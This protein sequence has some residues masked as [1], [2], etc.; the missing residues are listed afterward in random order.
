MKVI[1]IGRSHDN[2]V[3]IDDPYVGRHHCQIVQHDNGMFTIVDMNSTNGTYINGRRVFGEAQLQPYDSVTI[4]HTILPWRSYFSPKTESYALPIVLGSVGGVLLTIVLALLIFRHGSEK[5]FAFKGDYPDAVVVNMV[6]EDGT[7]Y[8]IEAIE[9]QVCVWFEEGTP[10][11]TAQK[12]I[13]ASGGRIVAQIPENG[14]YLVK[15]P[16]DKVNIFLNRIKKEHCVDWAY[17]NMISYSCAVYN[18]VLDNYY[19]DTRTKDTARHGYV[20]EYALQEY[21]SNVPFRHF[22]IGNENG[23]N[24]CASHKLGNGCVNSEFFALDTISRLNN[25]GPIFINM[26]YGP[27]LPKR[28]KPNGKPENYYWKEATDKEKETYQINY[29]KSLKKNH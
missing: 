4:G 12:S 14:Y 29:C 8:S 19:Q 2:D 5:A 22:N 18:Y 9:G 26:S 10:Y 17:P 13:K 25:N 28:E 23:F 27:S 24:L 7:Q 15:V 1:T 16:A 3:R 6:D 11:K 21:G 20:V